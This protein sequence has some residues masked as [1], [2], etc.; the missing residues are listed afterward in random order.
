MYMARPHDEK[1]VLLIGVSK[2]RKLF[3]LKSDVNRTARTLPRLRANFKSLYAGSEAKTR[4]I[5]GY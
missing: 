5:K 2:V 4:T 3:S 1:W